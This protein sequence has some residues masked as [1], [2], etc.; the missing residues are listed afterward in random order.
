MDIVVLNILWQKY[1]SFKRATINP[2]VSFQVPLF[3]VA[4]SYEI[5]VSMSVTAKY[6][7]FRNM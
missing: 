4:L 1:L 7:V 2:S 6:T 3:R 5:W